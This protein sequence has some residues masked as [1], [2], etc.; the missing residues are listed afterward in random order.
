LRWDDFENQHGT[1]VNMD[2]DF[3]DVQMRR[4]GA[5]TTWIFAPDDAR[6]ELVR[7]ALRLN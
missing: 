4:D 7:N 1:I 3:G 2:K 5:T 6:M